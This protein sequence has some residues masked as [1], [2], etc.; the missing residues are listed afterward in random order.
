M[1]GSYLE[2]MI[3]R[4][5]IYDTAFDAGIDRAISST[6][7][8]D[9][10]AARKFLG[11]PQN[12][13]AVVGSTDPFKTA[14][15]VA[16]EEIRHAAADEGANEELI[17]AARPVILA[18]KLDGSRVDALAIPPENILDRILGNI[19]MHL[20][21]FVTRIQAHALEAAHTVEF[22]LAILERLAGHVRKPEGNTSKYLVLVADI[23]QAD[24]EEGEG[25]HENVVRTAKALQ[26]IFVDT[27]LGDVVYFVK[28][29]YDIA[30]IL[31]DP[32]LKDSPG[33]VD[34]TNESGLA[35]IEGPE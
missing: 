22:R 23:D 1:S 30:N 14:F 11:R 10:D 31:N 17:R 4:R 16:L 8:W 27:G 3:S 32:V 15:D 25:I 9:C 2:S 6:S 33:Y 28:D 18:S 24:S 29:G 35:G 21:P 20:R 34:L 13:V 12:G 7:L 19:L 5:D 26:D